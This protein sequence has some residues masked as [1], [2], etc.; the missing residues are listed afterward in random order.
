M[1]NTFYIWSAF[2]G[3]W[4]VET[5]EGFNRILLVHIKGVFHF[6]LS[7]LIFT[8]DSTVEEGYEKIALLRKAKALS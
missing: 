7:L 8:H 5:D 3:C 1:H 6:L 2:I 4:N